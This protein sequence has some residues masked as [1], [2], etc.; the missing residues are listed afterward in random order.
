M[1]GYI[2][3]TVTIVVT[4]VVPSPT[5]PPMTV[6]LTPSMAHQVCV[7]LSWHAHP[8]GRSSLDSV[9]VDLGA[10]H[11]KGPSGG[12]LCGGADGPRHRAGRCTTWRTRD[13]SSAY[14][15]TVCA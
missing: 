9:G 4:T 8:R 3:A 13:S 1:V 6:R 5:F 10:K 14:V 2:N 7:V 12:A 15:Q 11:E